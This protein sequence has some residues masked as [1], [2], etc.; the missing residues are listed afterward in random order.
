MTTHTQQSH[1]DHRVRPVGDG[2]HVDTGTGY[3]VQPHAL[4]GWAI[5]TSDGHGPVQASGG[6]YALAY[7][8]SVQAIDAL[9]HTGAGQ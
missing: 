6:G 7:Q 1:A 3:L 9:L 5:F 4:L 8:T 2:F